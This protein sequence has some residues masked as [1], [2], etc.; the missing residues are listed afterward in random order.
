MVLEMFTTEKFRE[1]DVNC[2][3]SLKEQHKVKL[4]ARETRKVIPHPRKEAMPTAWVPVRATEFSLCDHRPW[5]MKFLWFMC[6]H[7]SWKTC[8]ALF[9]LSQGSQQLC[10]PAWGS[11]SR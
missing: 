11:S 10:V 4:Q 3:P 9:T 1:A 2:P 5:D 7:N 8:P 6:H